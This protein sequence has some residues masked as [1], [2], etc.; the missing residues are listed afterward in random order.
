V[1]D[2]VLLGAV[3]PDVPLER[4]LPGDDFLDGNLLVPAVA[5]VTF[6]PARLRE[7][8]CAAQDAP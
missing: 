2:E 6:V 3:R 1:V 5:A 4:E 8:L 7:F